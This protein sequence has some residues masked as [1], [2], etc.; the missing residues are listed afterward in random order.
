MN[1]TLNY[2]NAT[3]LLEQGK[4]RVSRQHYLHRQ[5]L[6][7]LCCVLGCICGLSFCR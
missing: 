4:D 2:T 5:Q 7:I 6:I 3:E 1:S